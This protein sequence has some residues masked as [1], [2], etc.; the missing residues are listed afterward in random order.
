MVCLQ[1]YGRH[2]V[3]VKADDISVAVDVRGTLVTVHMAVRMR[4]LVAVR[5]RVL[6]AVH[7]F[8]RCLVTVLFS[9]L[10]VHPVLTSKGKALKP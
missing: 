9:V 6:V 7:M 3:L 1:N 10:S 2:T 8:L 5:M 4:V